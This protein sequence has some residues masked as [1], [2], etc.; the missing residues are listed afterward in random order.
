MWKLSGHDIWSRILSLQTQVRKTCGNQGCKGKKRRCRRGVWTCFWA[1]FSFQC[2]LLPLQGWG[3]K[4]GRRERGESK[5]K[6]KCTRPFPH[7]L[8]SSQKSCVCLCKPSPKYGRENE[9]VCGRTM[10][11]QPGSVCVCVCASASF[12]FDLNN[13]RESWKPAFHPA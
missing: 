6:K 2:T 5:L 9:C 13:N 3:G 12:P 8:S 7:L 11:P 1:S 4:K 10:S